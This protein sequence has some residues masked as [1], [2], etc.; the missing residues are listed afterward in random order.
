MV[1]M[2]VSNDSE[3]PQLVS[4]TLKMSVLLMCFAVDCKYPP[5][6]QSNV[7]ESWSTRSEGPLSFISKVLEVFSPPVCIFS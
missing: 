2:Q 5:L 6:K 4:T 7:L 1:T 3:F